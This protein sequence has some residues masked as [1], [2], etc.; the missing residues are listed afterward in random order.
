MMNVFRWLCLVLR[1]KAPAG[2]YLDLATTKYCSHLESFIDQI[3]TAINISSKEGQIQ[4]VWAIGNMASESV[5]L[6]DKIVSK[7][8]FVC[9]TSK[10]QTETDDEY[11]QILGFALSNLI[12]GE[13]PPTSLLLQAD[14][15]KGLG[16]HFFNQNYLVVSEL[17]WVLVYVTSNPEFRNILSTFEGYANYIVSNSI[18]I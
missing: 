6:R 9:L 8:I 13:N 17:A 11:L 5:E 18:E 7:E 3:I 15:M 1:V 4:G 14:N 2:L 12:R 10:L 16:A